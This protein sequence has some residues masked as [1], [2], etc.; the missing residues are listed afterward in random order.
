MFKIVVL[1]CAFYIISEISGCLIVNCPRGGKRSDRFNSIEG[2]VKRCVSCGP[3]RTGQCFGENICCGTFGCLIATQETIV[4][5]KEGLFQEYEPCIAG[6]SFC[7]KH[8]G[9]CAADGICCDQESCR[10]DQSCNLDKGVPFFK[11]NFYNLLNYPNIK[12][13]N[14]E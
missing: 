6:R 12:E 9:R 13:Y 1:F 7:N 4:C 10:I 8:R 2:N 11:N 3:G 5:Q 14:N